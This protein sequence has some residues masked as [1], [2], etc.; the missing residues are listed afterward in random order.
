MKSRAAFVVFASL[1]GVMVGVAA[2]YLWMKPKA[3]APPVSSAPAERE[4]LYWYDPMAPAQRFD[5]PGKSPFMDMDLVAKYADEVQSGVAIDPALQQSL[6]VR[7]AV[8]EEGRVAA[9]I[10]APGTLTWDLRQEVI[11]STRV[12]GIVNRVFVKAPFSAVKRGAALASIIAP[13]WA[14]AVAEAE[15]LRGGESTASRNL[16][17]AAA[18]RLK[19]LGVPPGARATGAVTLTAPSSGAVNEIM[20]REGQA[21]VAG[22]PLFRINGDR[23]LWL[24]ASVPQS[25]VAEIRAG[26]PV[27][28]RV[29]GQTWSAEVEAVLPQVDDATR[30]QR[31]RIAIENAD[32][33]FA[34]GQFAEAT[35]ETEAGPAVPVVPTEALIATG[36]ESR[37]IVQRDGRFHAVA[38]QLGRSGH[39]RTEIRKGL[40]VGERVVV[41]GQ[42]LIDSEASLSG[43]LQRLNQDPHAG[44][45]P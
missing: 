3:D 25:R 22:T 6:G 15:A 14:S 42:F 27:T 40:E 32:G 5:K 38:V 12:D 28:V 7:T 31:V 1:L 26:N 44:H 13:D 11:V 23:T 36:T 16:G 45:Q 33:K 39:G 8:V 41:S 24:L 10:R 37:V 17:E 35:F 30:T 43:A 19:I 34:P 21:V 20:V 29:G 2:T 9:A 18:Q 4:V